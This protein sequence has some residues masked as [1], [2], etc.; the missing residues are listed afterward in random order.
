MK[1]KLAL[2]LLSLLVL[3]ILAIIPYLVDRY[4]STP[5]ETS[6][7]IFIPVE[8]HVE[9]GIICDSLRIERGVVRKNQSLS[10]ILS[11]YDIGSEIIH[12]IANLSR[13]VFLTRCFC[14]K[15]LF[16]KCFTLFMKKIKHLT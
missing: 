8:Q 6:E 7:Q 3:S 2:G 16:P 15:T 5:E 10:E 9:Y 14:P 12:Q 13:P 4:S 11:F 1:R